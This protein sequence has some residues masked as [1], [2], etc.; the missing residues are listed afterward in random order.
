MASR[1][2]GG[3]RFD[4]GA[5]FFT[6]R[7]EA[8]SSL[9]DD[10]VQAGVVTQW[11][12]G[13]GAEADGY[14]R[15][16]GVEAMTSLAKWMA[17]D[18]DVATG[19]TVTDLADHPASAYVLT[20][21]VPQS[22][23]VLSMSKLLPDPELA[24]RLATEITYRPTIAVMSTYTGSTQLLDHGGWQSP[25]H[26]AVTFIGD[27]QAKGISDVPALTFHLSEEWSHRWWHADDVDLVAAVWDAAAPVLG[28]ASPVASS[29]M[30]WR[31]AG[32]TTMWPTK[33]EVWGD[34]PVVA[35]AGEAF[36]G[37]KVEGAFL[38]G[39]AASDAVAS[40]LRSG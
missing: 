32:P 2:R 35:L 40:R 31:Y 10:A 34:D 14:P 39:L 30:R 17:T 21:P 1:R 25:D 6:T 16:R 36:D 9:I 37:P 26:P 27:N 19:V 5:Q 13:F 7:S 18:V 12:R 22:L 15:W 38:S 11:T 8:F 28:D 24:V 20:A 4:H 3:A 23:A 29:V 33:T